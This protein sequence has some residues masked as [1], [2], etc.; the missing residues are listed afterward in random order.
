MEKNCITLTQ[1]P[2]SRTPLY[3]A[4]SC[5]KRG[6]LMSGLTRQF[7]CYL[8]NKKH[9]DREIKHHV[10]RQ[11]RDFQFSFHHSYSWYGM[12]WHEVEGCVRRAENA[13][14]FSRARPPIKTRALN[15]GFKTYP[16]VRSVQM[17]SP[18][19]LF[20]SRGSDPGNELKNNRNISHKA[21]RLLCLV[22]VVSGYYFQFPSC[23]F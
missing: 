11:T 9:I 2:T 1:D 6:A 17:T 20:L 18:P 7:N 14:F 13:R 16:I 4:N 8:K 21:K 12:A 15:E 10:L 19:T 22:I 5:V 23:W 3:H